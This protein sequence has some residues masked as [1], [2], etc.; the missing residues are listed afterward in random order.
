MASNDVLELEDR[1]DNYSEFEE[2]SDDVNSYYEDQEDEFKEKEDEDTKIRRIVQ[3]LFEEIKDMKK[4]LQ[5]VK[6]RKRKREQMA[7]HDVSETESAEEVDSNEEEEPRRQSHTQNTEAGLFEGELIVSEPLEQETVEFLKPRFT[8]NMKAEQ[9]AK[10]AEEYHPPENATFMRAPKTNPEVFKL[11]TK[12]QNQGKKKEKMMYNMQSNLA[13]ACVCFSSVLDKITDYQPAVKK[14]RDG[15]TLVAT[16]ARQMSF[17]RRDKHREM[18]EYEN[19]GIC[20]KDTDLTEE[21]L[22]GRNVTKKLKEVQ[23]RHKKKQEEYKKKKERKN[24]LDKKERQNYSRNN[25]FRRRQN[26]YN[27]N[28]SYNQNKGYNNKNKK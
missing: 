19:R 6:S 2:E 5:E 27:N 20:D 24:F 14:M 10:V 15:L 26:Q 22:Y 8:K 11:F 16:T 17:L 12:D 1:E 21:F 7:T 3:P 23:E 4:Q 13:K 28:R 25:N 9:L 18:L